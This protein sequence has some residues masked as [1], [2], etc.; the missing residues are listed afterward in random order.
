LKRVV[1]CCRKVK[2]YCGSGSYSGKVLV[3]VPVPIPVP[4]PVQIYF[5]KFFNNKKFVQNLTFSILKAALFHRKL[6]LNF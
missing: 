6:A 1:Q 2:I 3:P 5:E 4:D